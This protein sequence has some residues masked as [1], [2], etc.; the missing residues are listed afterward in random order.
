[1]E[2]AGKGEQVTI[3]SENISAP[4]LMAVKWVEG[5]RQVISSVQSGQP[6]R[7]ILSIGIESVQV[8]MY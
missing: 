7:E 6:R 2:M 3:V 5:D 4:H 1:M 8:I